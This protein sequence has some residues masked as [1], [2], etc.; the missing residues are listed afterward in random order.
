MTASVGLDL[1]PRYLRAQPFARS[2]R[3]YRQDCRTAGSQRYDC[4]TVPPYLHIDDALRPE[5]KPQNSHDPRAI[6]VF[7][8][9]HKPGHLPRLNNAAAASP[10]S[11]NHTLTVEIIRIGD[12]DKT[13]EPMMLRY[14]SR[15][16][17]LI[18]PRLRDALSW[19][20]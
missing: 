11:R 3:L 1:L 13:W 17:L 8:H 10:T 4:D 5:R 6:E 9:Q 15:T 18:D 7:R 16:K 12:S 20:N 2:R 19:T 14:G